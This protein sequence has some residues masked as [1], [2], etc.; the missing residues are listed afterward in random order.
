[1]HTAE[2][3]TPVYTRHKLTVVAVG[4]GPVPVS[5]PPDSLANGSLDGEQRNGLSLGSRFAFS[6]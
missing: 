3:G 6:M 5:P 1:M 2:L 4:S